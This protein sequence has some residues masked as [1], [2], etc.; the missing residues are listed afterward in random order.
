MKT[1][2]KMW[3]IDIN[4]INIKGWMYDYLKLQEKGLTGNL[5][6]CGYPFDSYGWYEFDVGFSIRS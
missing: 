4:N 6:K 1:F 3:E 2:S 5:D